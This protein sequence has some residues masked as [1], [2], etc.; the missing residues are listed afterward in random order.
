MSENKI[1]K[2]RGRKSNAEKKLLLEEAKNNNN[3]NEN[4]NIPKK[5]GRK[6]KG[7]KIIEKDSTIE[8]NKEIVPNIILHLKCNN[9]DIKSFDNTNNIESFNI[10]NNNKNSELSYLLLNDNND[11]DNNTISSKNLSN[12]ED[13]VTKK[14][15]I[16]LSQ[17]NNDK[18]IYQK[19]KDLQTNLHTNNISDKKS[20]CFWCTYEFDNPPIY[21]P[22]FMIQN[23][24]HCYGCFCSPECSVAYLFNENIDSSVKFERY[25]LSNLIYSKIYNYEKN[26]KPAPNPYYILD[27]FYGNLSI[28]EYRQLL[29]YDRLLFIIDKPLTRILPELHKDNDDFLLSKNI[30][31]NNLKIKK[32]NS[33]I[34]IS[35]KDI[36]NE[37]FG[38]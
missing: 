31:Y 37:N 1:V 34:N 13:I 22:K 16:N 19:L 21:I 36:M 29:T 23:S 7:G 33:N 24:Y 38:F 9:N 2:K 18:E 6:P 14:N 3:V 25:H 26:I 27:K 35:K 17:T 8:N 4:I 30:S 5:R 11:N 12:N 10:L 15:Q 28:T 32:N 20:A